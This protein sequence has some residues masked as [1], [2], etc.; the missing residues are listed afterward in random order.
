[1]GVLTPDDKNAIN[2]AMRA[3]YNL[4]ETTPEGQRQGY[5]DLGYN[6]YQ[7]AYQFLL[8]RSYND[9]RPLNGKMAEARVWS[10]A[11]TEEQIYANMYNVENPQ[12]DP[13]LIGYWKFNEGSGDTIKDHSQYGNDGKAKYSLIWPTGVE[14]PVINKEEE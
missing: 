3:L 8:G 1:M 2:L 14:I 4:W 10:V 6:T 7:S 11:R 12:D 5:E 13:T 9:D